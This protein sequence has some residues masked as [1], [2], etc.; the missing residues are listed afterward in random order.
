MT[1]YFGS[2]ALLFSINSEKW[3]DGKDDYNK[4]IV[5]HQNL[6][7]SVGSVMLPGAIDIDEE[8]TMFFEPK[9]EGKVRNFKRITLCDILKKIYVKI[10]GRK[11][12]VF[13][14][15]FKTPHGKY[16]LWFWDTV[17]E[18]RDFVDVFS[19]QGAAYIWHRCRLWGWEFA[20]MKCLFTLSFDSLTAT[21]AM[22]SKWCS[23]R[24]C[25]VHIQM[26][27]EATAELNFGNSPFV[28]KDGE[29]K[30]SRQKK[31]NAVIQ[32]GNISPEEI[33]GVDADDLK[34]IA[35]TNLMRRLSL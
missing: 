27:A 31:E 34:S 8:V 11:I 23:K 35:V 33:G 24:N 25:A 7:R 18:I 21:S 28:L 19:T 6:N 1:Y 17:P 16:Q 13:L 4:L 22:N 12:S 9:Q 30:T 3:K 5:K 26:S 14:Y 29:D 10:G 15:C 2:N 32:R 20:P